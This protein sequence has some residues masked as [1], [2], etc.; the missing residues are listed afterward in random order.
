MYDTAVNAVA[1]KEGIKVTEDE[2]KKS[3]KQYAEASQITTEEFEKQNGK[4]LIMSEL[5]AEK[6]TATLQGK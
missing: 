3:V 4:T 2:Y 6:V 5:V 1:E